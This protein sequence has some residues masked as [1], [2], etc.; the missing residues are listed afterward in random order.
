MNEIVSAL[1]DGI[2]RLMILSLGVLKMAVTDIIVLFGSAG[3][4]E[5]DRVL[6]ASCQA[7]PTSSCCNI[8]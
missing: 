2:S 8:C 3:F 5:S 4:V 1:V 7:S 6:K